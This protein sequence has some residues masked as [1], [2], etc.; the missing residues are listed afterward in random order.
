M[1][2]AAWT[3]AAWE[4]G[5]HAGPLDRA[6]TLLAGLT[7]LPFDSADR[8]ELGTRD[9]ILATALRGL[10][11]DRMWTSTTCTACGERLDV[12]LG[13][14]LL[15]AFT[16]PQD[17]NQPLRIRVGGRDVPFRLPA[18]ADLRLVAHAGGDAA[19]GRRVLL[20]ALVPDGTALTDEAAAEV[21]AAMETASP[22]AVVS[23]AV[24]CPSCG[25][26]TTA[27]V[28]VAAMLWRHVEA[29]AAAMLAEVHTL[30]SAYGWP[31]AEILALSPARRGAYLSMVD[32]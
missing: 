7:G 10:A 25:T 24:G 11:G 17:Q 22:G 6:V 30:A 1:T 27:V 9:A 32:R 16:P 13:P 4:R 26:S 12:P 8:V 14:D 18:T 19:T 29:E 23:V 3:V 31:E 28:D 21:E 20:G 15:A 5:L 2:A